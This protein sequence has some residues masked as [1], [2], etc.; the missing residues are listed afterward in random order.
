MLKHENSIKRRRR[1]EL[2][3]RTVNQVSKTFISRAA[4]MACYIDL[5]HLSWTYNHVGIERFSLSVFNAGTK[6]MPGQRVNVK[7]ILP[8][9]N[10]FKAKVLEMTSEE[11][12]EDKLVY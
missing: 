8:S 3:P 9:A 11:R 10:T 4:A 5:L 1:N 6:M 12:D 2:I 7:D